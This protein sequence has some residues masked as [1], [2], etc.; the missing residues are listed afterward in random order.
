MYSI[1]IQLYIQVCMYM[2]VC[3]YMYIYVFFLLQFL[4]PYLKNIFIMETSNIRI[5]R[6]A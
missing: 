4:F 3:E 5:D 1:A 6:R 2:C